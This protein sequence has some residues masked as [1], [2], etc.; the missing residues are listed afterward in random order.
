MSTAKDPGLGSKY[1]GAVKRM[2]NSDGSYNI[3][4]KGGL[5]GFR[6]IYK[7]L[8]ELS[9]LKFFT[10]SILVYLIINIFFAFLYMLVGIKEISGL[11]AIH[12]DFLNAF[13][14]SVQ[15]FTTVGYGFLAPVGPWAG[16]IS[17]FEAFIGLMYFAL[18]TGLLW[19]RFSKPSA[20]IA[21][22]KNIILT[23]YKD[24]QAIMF[25]MV[26]QRKSVLIN[27]TVQCMLVLD[28]GEGKEAH[29]KQYHRI[30]LELD[31]VQFFPLTWTLVHA[32][33]E[34]SPFKGMTVKELKRRNAEM[35]VLVEAFDETFSQNIIKKHSFAEDQWLAGVK[36]ERNFRT[37]D[38]GQIE[39]HVHH[40]DRVSPLES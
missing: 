40:I 31:A 38:K 14:F 12:S 16:I 7:A 5:T 32:I 28:N 27:T 10:Y 17:T 36:F 33:N 9:W 19:G 6:D 18:I 20:K 4:R 3:V 37:N 24:G 8:I 21:F 25:K 26:N 23:N 39:L 29:N 35:I 2:I 11:N 34:E 1:T 15:T 13:F 22:A 30:P